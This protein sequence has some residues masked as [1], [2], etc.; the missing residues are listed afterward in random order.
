MDEYFLYEKESVVIGIAR[1]S[2]MP[3]LVGTQRKADEAP[4]YKSNDEE[5]DFRASFVKADSFKAKGGYQMD[6]LSPSNNS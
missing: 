6:R 5:P 1:R 2:S 4:I 3:N